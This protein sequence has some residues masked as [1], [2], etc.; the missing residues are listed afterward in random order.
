MMPVATTDTRG[1]KIPHT[2]HALSD[3]S[4]RLLFLPSL[5]QVGHRE[6]VYFFKAPLVLGR[7]GSRGHV[8]VVGVPG[9]DLFSSFG[10]GTTEEAAYTG[11]H[12]ESDGL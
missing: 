1:S 6:I 2:N 3:R 4:P 10:E 9:A 11:I 12:G 8:N 5:N 7:R